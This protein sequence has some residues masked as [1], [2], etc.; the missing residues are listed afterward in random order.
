MLVCVWRQKA[1]IRTVWGKK[2]QGNFFNMGLYL[3]PTSFWVN[4]SFPLYAVRLIRLYFIVLNGYRKQERRRR[5][6]TDLLHIPNAQLDQ[7]IGNQFLPR[8]KPG[9]HGQNAF[10]QPHAPPPQPLSSNQPKMKTP[11]L[12]RSKIP[13]H[14]RRSVR[15]EHDLDQPI[16]LHLHRGDLVRVVP[17]L[18]RATVAGG[19][20]GQR[21]HFNLK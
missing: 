21:N 8:F 1:E 19:L 4:F 18:G 7:I 2:T 15:V 11:H 5:V 13:P 14:G 16:L 9:L 10:A 12:L 20:N 3:V 6:Y 17:D